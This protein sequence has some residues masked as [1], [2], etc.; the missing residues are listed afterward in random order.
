MIGLKLNH[1]SNGQEKE[2]ES[3][4]TFFLDCYLR[5]MHEDK[6]KWDPLLEYYITEKSMVCVFVSILYDEQLLIGKKYLEVAFF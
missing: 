2:G 4:T 5:E 6:D 3:L 1:G